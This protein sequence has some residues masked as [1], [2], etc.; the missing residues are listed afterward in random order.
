[1]AA[2]LLCVVYVLSLW[3]ATGTDPMPSWA[4]AGSSAGA[5]ALRVGASNVY[6]DNT[7]DLSN[8]VTDMGADVLVFTEF[9]KP[10]EALM[11]RSGSLDQFP[12][13][14]DNAAEGTWRTKIFSRYP[15]VGQPRIVP[16]PG[17]PSVG[18]P[19]LLVDI[20][21]P[22]GGKARVIGVH[23]MPLTVSGARS[24]FNNTSSVLR[25]E[26]RVAQ[27]EGVPLIAIGDFN[28][29]RW[30]PQ[31]GELFDAGYRSAHESGGYGL[32]ASWPRVGPIPKFMRLDHALY[33]GAVEVRSVEDVTVIG[34][35]HSAILVE[36]AFPKP[37]A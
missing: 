9:A 37:T 24:A 19:L 35:D 23:P 6:V 15:F 10:V 2:L 5:T 31:T 33:V 17:T 22:S 18:T 25:E 26:L 7:N 34:S 36:F 14:S 20:Q 29:T 16:V 11:Q 30:L 27:L 13:R 4:V 1:V 12:Y 8:L 21:L 28:G 3:P 32:T